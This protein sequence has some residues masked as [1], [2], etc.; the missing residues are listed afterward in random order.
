M[1]RVLT[2]LAADGTAVVVSSHRMDDLE[3]LCSEVTILSAG[4]VLFTGPLAKL[5][6][7]SGEVDYRLVTSDRDATRELILADAELP[8]VDEGLVGQRATG[9]ALVIRAG[10]A[11]L[12]ELVVRLV[13]AGIAVRE[14]APVISRLESAFLALT[15]PKETGR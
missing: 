9:D 12:D 10:E 13:H 2:Q 15:E 11:A 14:L 4:R 3:A 5:S 6:A 7:E 8:L 1:H